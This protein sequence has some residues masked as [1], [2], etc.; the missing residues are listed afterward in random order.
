MSKATGLD[1]VGGIL[2]D[3][4]IVTNGVLQGSVLGPL[5]FL[6]GLYVNDIQAACEENMFLYDAGYLLAADMEAER[7]Q[8]KLGEDLVKV[9]EWLTEKKLLLHLGKSESI[10]LGSNYKLH[11]AKDLSVKVNSYVIANRTSVNY[12]GCV[13]D[14][15]LNGVNMAWKVLRKVNSRIKYI[16]RYTSFKIGFTVF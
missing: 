11:N 3:G 15:N 4:K 1:E 8:E 16:A 12:L 10:L 13:L 9:K 7:I 5:L 2:S 6:L 14:N